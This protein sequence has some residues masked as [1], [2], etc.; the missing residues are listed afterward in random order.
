[1]TGV[2]DIQPY[3]HERQRSW[4]FRTCGYRHGQEWFEFVSTLRKS[5]TTMC[6][7]RTRG[8]PAVC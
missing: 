2:F 7:H 1:M 5:A 8:H 4:I 6:F 3:T